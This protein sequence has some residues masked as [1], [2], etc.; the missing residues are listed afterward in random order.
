M[1]LRFFILHQHPFHLLALSVICLGLG[2]L[3]LGPV[4]QPQAYAT[5]QLP[6]YHTIALSN[7]QTDPTPTPFRNPTATPPTQG[8]H[9]H[10]LF[11]L[12]CMPCHGDRGQ[13]LTDEFRNRQYP[14]E[15]TN[16]W[17][18]GCHGVRPYD[19]G[20]TLPRQV[21]ALIGPGTLSHFNTAQDV[22]NFIRRAMPFNAPGSLSE[23]K[24]LQLLAF[25]LE[26]NQ[27]IPTGSQLDPA[28]LASI[29]LR[30]GS[31]TPAPT[32]APHQA[33]SFTLEPFLLPGGVIIALL[34]GL[35]LALLKRRRRPSTP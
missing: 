3:F 27:I 13:G 1:N 24:Y 17:K 25:I 7:Y 22:Y 11:Y 33:E 23:E 4:I 31:L 19:N 29:A 26:S 30:A 6:D 10:D 2:F 16:C 5:T 21:P 18:S 9:G 28:S 35:A 20:F 34:V 15:D 8:G 14:P 12:Y 32:G